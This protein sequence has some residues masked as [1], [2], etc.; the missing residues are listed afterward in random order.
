VSEALIANE[1][2]VRLA[3]F[4]AVLAIM[5]GLEAALPRR[6]RTVGRWTRWPANLGIVALNTL[7]LRL[8]L[9]AGAVGIAL[10]L[11]HQGAGLLPWF[12]LPPWAAFIAA[13]VLLDFAI[14]SMC[15]STPCQSMAPAPH[16]PCRPRFRRHYRQPLPRSRSCCRWPSS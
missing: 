13:L 5:A 6:A 14:Y 15:C 12:G 4:V 16:A 3:I 11:E 2:T 8:L 10:A 7:L 9:P 1:S